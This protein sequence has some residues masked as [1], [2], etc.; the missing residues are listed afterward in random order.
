MGSGAA[1]SIPQ[2]VPTGRGRS[3]GCPDGHGAGYG[4]KRSTYVR[5]RPEDT[6]LHQVIRQHLET[7]LAEARRRGGGGGLPRFVERELREFLTCG[8]LPRGFGLRPSLR[9]R[10]S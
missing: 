3:V 6:V 9:T 8:L 2:H 1:T 7:F 5:R 4:R 10:W